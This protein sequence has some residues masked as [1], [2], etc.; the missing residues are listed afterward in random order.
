GASSAPTPKSLFAYTESLSLI[1]SPRCNGGAQ[2]FPSPRGKQNHQ[3]R[4]IKK[5]GRRRDSR[6][7]TLRE[8]PAQLTRTGRHGPATAPELC[9]R[10]RRPHLPLSRH[11]AD[12]SL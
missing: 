6:H 12:P 8:A 9:L 3:S 4:G 11:G 1:A 5:N 7:W 2:V 10:Q